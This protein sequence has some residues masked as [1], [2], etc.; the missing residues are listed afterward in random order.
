[1]SLSSLNG[2][3]SG[4]EGQELVCSCKEEGKG[5]IQSNEF[6][7][8]EETSVDADDELDAEDGGASCIC[9]WGN[10]DHT[11]AYGSGRFG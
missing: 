2:L 4:N 3:G 10:E 9:G 7:A 8:K 11:A 5:G 1:L 6:A